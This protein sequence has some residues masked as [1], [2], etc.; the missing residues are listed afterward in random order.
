MGST[1]LAA[2]EEKHE[3][4][5]AARRQRGWVHYCRHSHRREQKRTVLR[6]TR[7]QQQQNMYK[8]GA[9]M[10]AS[11]AHPPVSSLNKACMMK[12]PHPTFLIEQ[13]FSNTLTTMIR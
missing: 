8:V 7:Q 1:V 9:R 10:S 6:L 11:Q 12:P 13:S 3:T 2:D 5:Q 4:F